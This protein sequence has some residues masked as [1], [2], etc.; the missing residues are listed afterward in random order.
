MNESGANSYHFMESMKNWLQG[1]ATTGLVDV[2][3]FATGKY[4]LVLLSFVLLL[5]GTFRDMHFYANHLM[6]CELC[7]LK[8]SLK[9]LQ[10]IDQ[11]AWV[12]SFYEKLAGYENGRKILTGSAMAL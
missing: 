9:F 5:F 2:M 8:Y 11:P 3:P 12:S 1:Y 10:E 7:Q 4:C 6:N